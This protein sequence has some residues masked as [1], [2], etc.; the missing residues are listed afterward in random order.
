MNAKIW[1]RWLARLFKK[2]PAFTRRRVRP[3]QRL[4]FEPLEDRLTPATTYTWTGGGGSGNWSVAT[5]WS[6]NA[7]LTGAQSYPQNG[8]NLVFPALIAT[9]A[10]PNP[11]R[12]TNDNLSS[13]TSVNSITFS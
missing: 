7:G 1:G 3:Q 4:N 11:S 8:A 9:P 13:L 10:I 12:P 6:N 5:N 2:A